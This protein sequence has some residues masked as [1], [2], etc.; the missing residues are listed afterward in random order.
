LCEAYNKLYENGEISFPL[1]D[2]HADKIDTIVKT[3]EGTWFGFS[4]YPTDKDKAAAF[5][6][7]IIKDHPVTD[8]NKRLS[9][10][11]LEI[12]CK[13]LNLTMHPKITLDE[14]AV[15][16]E[17]DKDITIKELSTI[18]SIIIFEN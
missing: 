10:L 8:G 14:L 16:V 17:N 15:S 1:Q 9:V 4:Q 5:F 11:W 13:A 6:C 12:Y 2:E 7:F 3:I 18:V